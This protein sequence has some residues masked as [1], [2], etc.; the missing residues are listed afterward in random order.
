MSRRPLL[1]SVNPLDSADPEP[2]V[3][4]L[5]GIFQNAA[6][7][8]RRDVPSAKRENVAKFLDLAQV[9]NF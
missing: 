2:L 9:S 6:R 1:G 7:I 4:L 3:R 5:N 8:D